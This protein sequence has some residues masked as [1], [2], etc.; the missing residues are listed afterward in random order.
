[1]SAIS[2]KEVECN[3]N[4]PD[5]RHHL[6]APQTNHPCGGDEACYYGKGGGI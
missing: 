3:R 4:K 1:M 5:G 6:C 2:A